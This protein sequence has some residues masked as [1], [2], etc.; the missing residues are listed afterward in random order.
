MSDQQ[1]GLEEVRRRVREQGWDVV[2]V[3]ARDGIPRYSYTVGLSRRGLSEFI[4]FGFSP[5]LARPALG[6]LA[7]RARDG[8]RFP[9]GVGLEDILPGMPAVLLDVPET[10]ARHYLAAAREHAPRTLRALQIVWPDGADRFPWQHGYD[11]AF[12]ARQVILNPFAR[13]VVRR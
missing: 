11:D 7:Q 1:D 5:D 13:T 9:S 8:E 6:D 10:E 2:S 12:R 3:P 4:V